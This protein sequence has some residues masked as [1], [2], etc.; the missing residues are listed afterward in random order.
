MVAA[1]GACTSPEAT[2]SPTA[3][4][5]SEIRS[6]SPISSASPS[7]SS[8][9]ISKEDFARQANAI[10][11]TLNNKILALPRGNDAAGE[12]DYAEKAAVLTEESLKQLRALPTPPADVAAINNFYTKLDDALAVTRRYVEV[13][14]SGINDAN[15]ARAVNEL[16]LKSNRLIAEANSAAIAYGLTICG[17]G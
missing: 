10:C 9:T 11:E 8:S 7:Q 2:P 3:R 16:A 12:A 4:T 14:R 13:L 5:S 6:P 1:L 15:A 17:Q